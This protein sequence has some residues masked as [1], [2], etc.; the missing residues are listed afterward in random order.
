MKKLLFVIFLF[1][2]AE[3]Y[4]AENNLYRFA[5]FQIE[6][7]T[8]FCEKAYLEEFSKDPLPDAYFNP[9]LP[10][11]RRLHYCLRRIVS[12][13]NYQM[14]NTLNEF[15]YSTDE[16]SKR[17]SSYKRNDN[18]F[19]VSDKPRGDF[20]KEYVKLIGRLPD[21]Y[22]LLA[23]D[24]EQRNFIN[25]VLLKYYDEEKNKER[26][27]RKS[28]MNKISNAVGIVNPPLGYVFMGM[29]AIQ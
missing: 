18:W 15:S 6:E 21:E 2:Y 26:A 3:G 17:H 5:S 19:H 1:F 25:E 4:C 10:K 7:L 24:E 27:K 22:Y 28:L 13:G 12:T 8:N 29:E 11:A 20:E 23:T 9:K 14:N 16:G